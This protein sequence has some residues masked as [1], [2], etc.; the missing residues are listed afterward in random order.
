MG[1]RQRRRASYATRS[2]PGAALTPLAR[3]APAAYRL[4]V[5]HIRV[6][7]YVEAPAEYD[8]DELTVFL[9]GGITGTADWQETVAQA[10][11]GEPVVVLNPRRRHFGVDDDQKH[12]GQVRW[13]I[14]MSR[15]TAPPSS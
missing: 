15:T 10:L 7:R 2:G 13:G 8:G 9:A 12:A 6:D 11:A 3:A 1:I 5:D 4:G 14:Y